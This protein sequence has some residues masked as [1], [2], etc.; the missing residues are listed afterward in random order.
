MWLS[1]RNTAAE[2]NALWTQHKPVTSHA[3][4][5]NTEREGLDTVV[6]PWHQNTKSITAKLI[7]ISSINWQVRH[8]NKAAAQSDKGAEQAC[9]HFCNC[10][11]SKTKQ[12]KTSMS[13]NNFS[14]AGEGD[15][16]WDTFLLLSCGGSC[17]STYLIA[18]R[19]C[20]EPNS[21]LVLVGTCHFLMICRNRFFFHA[22]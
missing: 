15:S 19:C 22:F 10:R 3:S 6:F 11:V 14:L 9:T 8:G 5:I 7:R 13:S 20:V 12:F 17:F 1:P 16:A 18:H 2:N 21:G 4:S